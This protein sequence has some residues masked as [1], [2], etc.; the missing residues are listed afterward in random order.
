M[1]KCHGDVKLSEDGVIQR[2]SAGDSHM[3]PQNKASHATFLRVRW[4]FRQAGVQRADKP[5]TAISL[6][7]ALT[8]L[9]E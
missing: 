2:Q 4:I 3:D 5:A 1:S 8:H 9:K 6:D 7:S